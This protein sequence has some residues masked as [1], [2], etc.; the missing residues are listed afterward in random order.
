MLNYF[1][2]DKSLTVFLMGGA[3]NKLFQIARAHSLHVAGHKVAVA[4]LGELENLIYRSIGFTRHDDWLDLRPIL[5]SL[6]I[7][8]KAVTFSQLLCL[9]WMFMKRFRV[10]D[11]SFDSD[12]EQISSSRQ[13]IDVG[14]FQSLSKIS[15]DSIHVVADSILSNQPGACYPEVKDY[16]VL[17]LRGGDFGAA[18]RLQNEFIGRL[19]SY[20]YQKKSS[21]AVVTNDVGFYRELFDHKSGVRL[22]SNDSTLQDFLCLV[23]SR[24]LVVSNSTFSFWAMICA[25]GFRRLKWWL[26]KIIF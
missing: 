10:G 19:L 2:R 6:D 1:V 16:V 8:L 13:S 26:L 5:K 14:Y 12:L 17:H 24:R 11:H 4:N 7:P 21:L 22:L 23:N 9:S 25:S 15:I 20:C 18:S 3:G